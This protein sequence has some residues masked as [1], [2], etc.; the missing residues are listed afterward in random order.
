VEDSESVCDIFCMRHPEGAIVV[1]TIH[2]EPPG[3]GIGL[4]LGF[5]VWDEIILTAIVEDDENGIFI[6]G[7]VGE[8]FGQRLFY[9][10]RATLAGRTEGISLFLSY[11]KV[12]EETAAG[13]RTRRFSS[14][15]TSRRSQARTC[16]V[17]KAG[18][19]ATARSG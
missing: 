7:I 12:L 19:A 5:Q 16:N 14:G 17:F 9:V 15:Q 6:V 18:P 10:L 3:V 2:H 13:V 11:R 1:P 8:V 4:V